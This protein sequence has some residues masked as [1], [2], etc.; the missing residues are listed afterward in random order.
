MYIDTHCHL[1]F[2][3]FKKKVDEVIA[4]AR[5]AGV[6]HIVI[7]GTDVMSSQK[8]VEIARRNEGIYA[9]VGIHPH[10][11]LSPV[12]PRSSAQQNDEG[13]CSQDFSVAQI[14]KLLRNDKNG[15]IVAVGEIGLDRHTY[16]QTKYENYH[17]NEA[18]IDA[19][20]KLFE[21]QFRLAKKYKK[22]IIIHNREAKD[23]I[24]LLIEN[25][26]SDE[27]KNRAVFHCCEPDLEL[28]DFAQEHGIFIGVDGDITYW[29]EKTQFIKKVPLEMLVLETDAPFLLPEPLRSE[30]K[31]P[32]VPANIP[33][34]AQF[35]SEVKGVSLEKLSEQTTANAHTLFN[36]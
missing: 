29:K 11:A 14:E 25:N 32:N 15:V 4:A 6:I 9:A 28:L 27:L 10:H 31:Y 19:Q 8:A 33:L 16:K 3:R 20:K 18:F 13:S 2:S 17:V 5:S 36:L 22:S 26:W 1:N 12:I 21:T 24:L 23:D 30:K 35:V 34:I 7:P